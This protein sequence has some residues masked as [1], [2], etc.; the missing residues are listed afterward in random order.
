MSNLFYSKSFIFN[1]YCN[2]KGFAAK[3][4]FD[5][6]KSDLREFNDILELFFHD[7]EKIT[8]NNEDQKKNLK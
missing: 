5:S 6:K 4:S 2:A 7:T 3:R 8:P 1:K